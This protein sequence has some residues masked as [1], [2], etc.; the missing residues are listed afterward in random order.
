MATTPTSSL[1]LSAGDIAAVLASLA[2]SGDLAA[3]VAAWTPELRAAVAVAV[4]LASSS[5]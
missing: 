3:E 4:T 2:E 5:T 1:P